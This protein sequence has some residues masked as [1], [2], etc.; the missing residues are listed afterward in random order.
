MMNR[1]ILVAV[2]LIPALVRAADPVVERDPSFFLVLGSRSV[3]V[4]DLTIEPPGCSIGV[5]CP[6]P[7]RGAAA[8]CGVLNATDS[9]V[10][11]SGQVVG[12]RVCLNGA[13][14]SLFEVFRNQA[15]TCGLNCGM[16]VHQSLRPD[17]SFPFTPP[18]L[19]DLDQDGV[20]SCD[21]H[22]VTDLDD[23]A[24][25]CGVTLPFAPCDP[26][27]PVTVQFDQDCSVDD[28]VP[29][30]QRCD[31]A[32]GTY[33]A[34]RIENEGELVLSPGTTTICSLSARRNV[35]I[36]STGPATVLVPGSGGVKFNNGATVGTDC[37]VLRIV[38]ERGSIKFSKSGTFIVDACSIAGKI[39]LGGDN[40]LRGHFVGGTTVAMDLGNPGQCCPT[41]TSTTVT[42]TS[43]STT[44]A[45]PTT[46]PFVTSTTGTAT[47]TATTATTTTTPTTAPLITS[48]SSTSSTTSTS[49]STTVT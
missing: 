42:T 26:A 1:S 12:D 47:T 15:N 9:S 44:T 48:T 20:P 17:C 32:A 25:A 4:K 19:R 33:G 36:T 39:N 11:A 6:V 49:S 28:L 14:G 45:P 34:I 31:L 3:H 37:G 22:C 21:N 23:I 10:P 41:T 7:V 30:N 8:R 35:K 40:L 27:R 13:P 18:I 43:S 24:R 29:G 16:V 2:V 5:N 38:T 46:A